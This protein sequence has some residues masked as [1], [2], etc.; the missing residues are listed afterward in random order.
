MQSFLISRLNFCT[1]PPHK[2]TF[3]VHGQHEGVVLWVNASQ[4]RRAY[5]ILRK[6]SK[7]RHGPVNSH[8]KNLLF[9]Y[10]VINFQSLGLEICVYWPVIN[11]QKH[12]TRG[13]CCGKDALVHGNPRCC[14]HKSYKHQCKTWINRGYKFI[15]NTRRVSQ[16]VFGDIIIVKIALTYQSI[17]AAC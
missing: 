13:V 6:V 14:I 9:S 17:K 11:F 8:H 4:Q 12:T 16:K 2:L 10:T 5:Q 3:P 15:R 1:H 7:Q